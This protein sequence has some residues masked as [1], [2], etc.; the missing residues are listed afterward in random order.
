MNIDIICLNIHRSC[1]CCIRMITTLCHNAIPICIDIQIIR[2][3]NRYTPGKS[4]NGRS[5]I[6]QHIISRA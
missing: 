5:S 1:S 4:M 2:T 3:G 6:I